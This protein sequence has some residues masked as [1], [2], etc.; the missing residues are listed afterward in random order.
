MSN[1]STVDAFHDLNSSGVILAV[2]CSMLG[3][4]A[5]MG[6]ELLTPEAK[7]RR[8]RTS[9]E[10]INHDFLLP[11][12]KE[13]NKARK[14][15][16]SR[17]VY[18]M[19]NLMSGIYWTH[20]H[21]L[22]K[23]KEEF[24]IHAA[25]FQVKVDEFLRKY[26][27]R[28]GGVLYEAEER[29]GEYYDVRNYPTFGEARSKFHLK[30]AVLQIT[31]VTGQDQNEMRSMV[32]EFKQEV[33]ATLRTQFSELLGKVVE[34]M[35]PEYDPQTGETKRKIFRDSLVSN[36]TEFMDAAQHLNVGS[37]RELQES[38]ERVREFITSR[39]VNASALRD[40]RE[41]QN[42][43]RD[44]FTEIAETFESAI[45][46]ESRRRVRRRRSTPQPED[47]TT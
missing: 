13:A 5:Q 33:T 38:M 32:N 28:F 39:D 37:D 26:H 17:S 47:A 8:I 7:G 35:T 19:K 20:N 18:F 24:A 6:D 46:V 11:I 4:T 45:T 16:K 10:L 21:L 36:L 14:A 41:L 12:L 42:I 15:V 31:G 25:E 44:R 43:V 29:L 22:D 1:T 2:R 3:T 30:L 9:A 27:N 34:K 23:I 40:D